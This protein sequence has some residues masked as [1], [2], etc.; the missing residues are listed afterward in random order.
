MRR[1]RETPMMIVA[2]VVL[3]VVIAGL[4]LTVALTRGTGANTPASHPGA[5]GPVGGQQGGRQAGRQAGQQ[6][7][8]VSQPFKATG[9]RL[10]QSQLLQAG[11]YA[12]QNN[13]W[14]SGADECI[15]ANGSGFSVVTSAIQNSTSGA[16][17]GYP[18]IYRGCHWGACTAGSGLPVAVAKLAPGKVTTSW[19]TTQPRT[20]AYDVAY[21]I[22]F[23]T[24]PQTSGQPDGTELMIWLNH[25]GPVQP[26]G[27]QAATATIAGR[28]YN[29]W[30]GRQA[31][32]TVSYTMTT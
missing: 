21:D 19:A 27:S 10:C 1:I 31:W 26:F 12:L 5:A 18:S 15:S 3:A 9:G 24:T 28:S 8:V 17:G 2:A 25:N 30:F 11:P 4:A 22:W 29:V 7:A 6:G 16:P 23:N 13:E 14:G 20:G 32:N